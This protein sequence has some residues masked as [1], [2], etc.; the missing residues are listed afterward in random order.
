M[1]CHTDVSC[2]AC[3]PGL[4]HI[5][6]YFPFHVYYFL[7]KYPQASRW[8]SI[9]T[10]YQPKDLAH[11]GSPEPA[12]MQI[13]SNLNPL[14]AP[15][16]VPWS[17]PPV[18]SIGFIMAVMVPKSYNR[19]IV[20]FPAITAIWKLAL[21][22]DG[23]LGPLGASESS[24]E[25]SRAQLYSHLEGLKCQNPLLIYNFGY[26]GVGVSKNSSPT[27]SKA[28]LAYAQMQ[29]FTLILLTIILFVFAKFYILNRTCPVEY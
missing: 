10:D 1:P 13:W 26:P 11:H 23:C 9:S 22:P 18:A 29:N 7:D 17:P 21:T 6:T 12:L 2:L 4:F 28:P 24:L 3:F 19:E 8:A 20:I 25:A 16:A 15:E 5:F 27:N 14:K